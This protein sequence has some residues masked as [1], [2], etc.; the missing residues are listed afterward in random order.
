MGLGGYACSIDTLFWA[1]KK[2]RCLGA[3]HCD[4]GGDL[5]RRRL[6][7]ALRWAFWCWRSKMVQPRFREPLILGDIQALIQATRAVTSEFLEEGKPRSNVVGIGA[8]V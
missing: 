7:V 1:S 5:L 2:L 8:G 4:D 6:V 3:N